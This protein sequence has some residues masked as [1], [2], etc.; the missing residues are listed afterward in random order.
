MAPVD[1]APELALSGL[2]LLP[3]DELVG[4]DP[5]VSPARGDPVDVASCPPIVPDVVAAGVNATVASV[6]PP[7]AFVRQY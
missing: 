6:V 3:P 5:F 2:L 7:A 4:L 1:N